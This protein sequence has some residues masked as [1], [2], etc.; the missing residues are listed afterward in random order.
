MH[1]SRPQLL[2]ALC[3]AA[4]LSLTLGAASAD[5]ASVVGSD[6]TISGCY[7]KKGKRK[8]ALRVVPAKKRCKKGERRVSWH[9]QGQ[10]GQTGAPGGSGTVTTNHESRISQ[11]ETQITDLQSQLAQLQSILAGVTNTDLLDAI[12]NAAKLDGI[13]AQNLSD[14]VASLASVDSLCTEMGTVVGQVNALR[15]VISGISLTGIIPAGLL[16]T[17]PSLPS[18]L[19]PYTCP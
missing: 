8:G 6:G 2:G 18:A 17:I 4:C 14:T 9:A 11:L 1:L 3:A 12:S 5:A 13:S 16:L 19:S 7:V 10:A 15:T